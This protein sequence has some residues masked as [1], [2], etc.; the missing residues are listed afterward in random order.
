MLNNYVEEYLPIIRKACDDEWVEVR[1]M[2]K[3]VL[4]E[5]QKRNID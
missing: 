3:W 2:A 4:E 5:L 1:D